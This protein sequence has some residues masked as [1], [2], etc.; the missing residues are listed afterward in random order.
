MA[1]RMFMRADEVAEVL[2][3]SIPYAYKFIQKLNRELEEKGYH[4][5]S[6]RVDRQY[7]YDKFY[8][9]KS[10]NRKEAENAGL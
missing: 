9:G 5:I 8:G 3:V 10:D 2:D 7:F 1:G 6:G 4:V